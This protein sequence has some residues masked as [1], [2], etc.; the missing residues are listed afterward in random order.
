[1]QTFSIEDLHIKLKLFFGV[2]IFHL[3]YIVNQSPIFI[4][5]DIVFIFILLKY[6]LC[7]TKS[8]KTTGLTIFFTDFYSFAC[9][10]F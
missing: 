3:K 5:F 4:I 10:F 2:F 8:P 7:Y 1:M 6:R 9:M